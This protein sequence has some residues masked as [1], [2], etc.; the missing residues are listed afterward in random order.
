MHCFCCFSLACNW[1]CI[2]SILIRI[3]NPIIKS[4]Y[5]LTKLLSLS[6]SLHQDL[7]SHMLKDL[8]NL[9]SLDISRNAIVHL[10]KGTFGGLLQLEA[11]NI[12]DCAALQVN[13]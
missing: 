12:S 11:L 2:Q 8:S 6:L 7:P 3:S 5:L 9:R 13:Y 4:K 10:D 1:L